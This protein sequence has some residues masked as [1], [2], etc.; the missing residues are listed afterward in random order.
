MTSNF[1]DEL[2][3]FHTEEAAAQQY[4]YAYLTVGEMAKENKELLQLIQL[5]PWFFVSAH[6]A[7]LVAMFV[8]LGRIF[9][10][11]SRHNICTLMKA[12]TKDHKE[13]SADALKSRLMNNGLSPEAAAHHA[14][15]SHELT[16]AEV[17]MLSTRVA[18]WS[19]VYN[20]R[21]RPIRNKVFAHKVLSSSTTIDLLFEKTSVD[22]LKELFEF[23][24]ALRLALFSAYENG[25]P[26]DP[27]PLRSEDVRW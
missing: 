1:V 13:F 23:L 10:H 12:I 2:K 4:F 26:I 8:A 27:E 20:Q 14:N 3:I 15:R 25:N 17:A 7:M 19:D 6:H 16:D 22:E 24:S 9:D 11:T 21:Y 18:A 5:H